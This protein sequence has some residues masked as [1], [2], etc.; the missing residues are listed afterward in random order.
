MEHPQSQQRSEFQPNDE[1]MSGRFVRTSKPS[2]SRTTPV[3]YIRLV[4]FSFLILI[5]RFAILDS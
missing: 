4:R 1:G 5:G 2:L 3:P